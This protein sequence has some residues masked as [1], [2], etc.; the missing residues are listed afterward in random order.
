MKNLERLPAGF[1][2]IIVRRH[3]FLPY[4]DWE[5]LASENNVSCDRR[6]IK[7]RDK[8]GVLFLRRTRFV[9][10][11]ALRVLCMKDVRKNDNLRGWGIRFPP[12]R[13]QTQNLFNPPSMRTAQSNGVQFGY[14]EKSASFKRRLFEKRFRTICMNR[15]M[16]LVKNLCI[17]CICNAAFGTE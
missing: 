6:S 11:M 16:R 9:L 12:F 3:T 5:G 14:R 2:H 10:F 7:Y 4:A 15:R 1:T 17:S 13:E 8:K